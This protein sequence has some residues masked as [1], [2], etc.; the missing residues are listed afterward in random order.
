MKH[1]VLFDTGPEEEAWERNVKRLA[2]ELASIEVI[3]LSHW[4]RDHSGGYLLLRDHY[5]PLTN[6][7]RGYAQS[8]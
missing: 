7:T 6:Y 3:H 2:P 4:H 5:V 1:S 8:H